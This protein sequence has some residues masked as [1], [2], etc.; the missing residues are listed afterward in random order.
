M[1]LKQASLAP[2][3]IAPQAHTQL[4]MATNAGLPSINNDER[5]GK[6]QKT[7]GSKKTV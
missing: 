7:G 6:R 4:L 5:R 2:Y 1:E 3:P